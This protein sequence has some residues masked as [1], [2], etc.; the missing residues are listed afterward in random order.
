[1]DG[2][3]EAPYQERA[4]LVVQALEAVREKMSSRESARPEEVEVAKRLEM[5]A[6]WVVGR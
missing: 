4:A 2:W 3:R 6:L 1:V 5:W